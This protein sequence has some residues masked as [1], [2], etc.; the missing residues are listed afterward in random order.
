MT[1]NAASAA[2]QSSGQVEKE[3]DV[4]CVRYP[5]NY[6]ALE[7]GTAIWGPKY[8]DKLDV[9][10]FFEPCDNHATHLEARSKMFSLEASKQEDWFKKIVDIKK[11]LPKFGSHHTNIG[12]ISDVWNKLVDEKFLSA[13]QRQ[14]GLKGLEYV[15]FPTGYL[16]S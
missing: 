8:N 15:G 12:I 14:Q 3:I 6:F 4:S 2:D 16:K 9:V 10:E 1:S 7:I 13:R 5:A 11:T